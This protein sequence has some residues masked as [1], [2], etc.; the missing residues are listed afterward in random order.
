MNKSFIFSI[1]TRCETE[2]HC[3]LPID[4]VKNIQ[5]HYPD[6]EIVIVDS[7]SPSNSHLNTLNNMGCTISDLINVNYEAGAIWDTFSKYDRDYYIFL[8][9]SMLLLGNIDF[10]FEKEVTMV[11]DIHHSWSG[12]ENQ[13]IDWI[14]ENI[15][16][17]NYGL[18]DENFYILQY[19]S[20]IVSKNL[21]LKFKSNNLDKILPINKIG[22]CGT[23]RTFGIALSYEG[24]PADASIQLPQHLIK[25]TWMNRQ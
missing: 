5:T 12:C 20:M 14:K 25:K 17:S 18:F 7:N 15:S 3:T 6:C 13:H 10:C 16:L 23:E 11:G 4:C 24:F 2:T 9:D 8:Q 21:M 22:S 1:S 19:N